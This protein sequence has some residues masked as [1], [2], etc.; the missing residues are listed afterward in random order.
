LNNF[1]ISE[2]FFE[3]C[4]KISLNCY[5]LILGNEVGSNINI[6]N[7]THLT[8]LNEFKLNQKILNNFELEYLE[9]KKTSLLKIHIQNIIN[10]QKSL[11]ILK[12][13][14]ILIKKINLKYPQNF[15]EIHSPIHN[16]KNF[17]FDSIKFCD[18]VGKDIKL[19]S[20]FQN[21]EKLN[22]KISEEDEEDKISILKLDYC[23]S[24]RYLE[25]IFNSSIKIESKYLIFLNLT[26]DQY[27]SKRQIDC[28]IKSCFKLY[29][30]KVLGE[31]I[32]VLRNNIDDSYNY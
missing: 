27:Y 20:K 16:F 3:K 22:L 4:K 2:N 8:I 14:Y 29:S 30:L 10:S 32:N 17:P 15:I 12:I 31:N 7:V 23:S 19:L 5:K 18:L 1:I 24:L 6:N 25:L 11:K 9:F 21:L 26:R 28:D 13:N